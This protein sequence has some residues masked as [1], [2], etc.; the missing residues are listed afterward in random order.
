MMT[1]NYALK[2][3]VKSHDQKEIRNT[4]EILELMTEIPF[5]VIGA[6]KAQD[7][8]KTKKK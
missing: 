7:E 6:R 3:V 4:I 2:S 1:V 5:V 8:K